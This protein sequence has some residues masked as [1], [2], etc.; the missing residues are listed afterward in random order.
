[1]SAA[2]LRRTGAVIAVSIFMARD[3][4]QR[5]AG[6]DAGRLPTAT[7]NDGAGHRDISTPC[8]TVG[9][10]RLADAGGVATARAALPPREC[11]RLLLE[12]RQR[13]RAGRRYSGWHCVEVGMFGEQASCAHRPR[14]T[15]R[16]DRIARNCA[17]LVGRPRNMEFV[18]RAQACDRAPKRT[19]RSNS[20]GRS[21][22]RTSDRIAAAAH[23]PDS[24]TNRPAHRDPTVPYSAVNMP[25]PAATMRACTAKPRG[26][27]TAA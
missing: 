22:W 18:Q 2:R 9:T 25:R 15:A 3:D 11:G 14:A 6:I 5:L 10:T 19:S 7:L 4:H 1:M 16:C 13:A 27:P 12:Q 24:R 17:R 21:A 23:S 8:S 26:V 20:I